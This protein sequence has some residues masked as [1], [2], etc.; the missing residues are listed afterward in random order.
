MLLLL[1]ASQRKT[2][3]DQLVFNKKALFEAETANRFFTEDNLTKFVR[4][5]TESLATLFRKMADIPSS[6]DSELKNVLHPNC[7]EI[8]ST[9][10]KLA[11]DLLKKTKHNENFLPWCNTL[12]PME[13]KKNALLYLES[14]IRNM[15]FNDIWNI[16]LEAL[17]AGS[18]INS[19]QTVNDNVKKLAQKPRI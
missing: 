16:A 11:A 8:A 19:L 10:L 9:F 18:P 15:S 5:N 1:N 4:D 17:P 3:L 2:L 7:L 14:H 12:R 6:Q 13:P